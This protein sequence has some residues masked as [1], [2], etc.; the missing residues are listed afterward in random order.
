MYDFVKVF[1][2]H[3]AEQW[4]T[5]YC[6]RYL[7]LLYLANLICGFVLNT[8]KNTHTNIVI[9]LKC[10]VQSLMHIYSFWRVLNKI[11][12]DPKIHYIWF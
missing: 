7:E 8:R 1:L 4:N 3:N 6:I 10:I 2:S 5:G 12:G 9:G 11:Y